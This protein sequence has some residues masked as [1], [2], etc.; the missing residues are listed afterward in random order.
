MRRYTLRLDGFVS[1]HGPAAEDSE[2]ITKVVTFEGAQMHLNFS[3]SA[4]GALRV[5][6][7]RPEGVALKN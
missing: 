6:V 1:V 7:Q 2:L 5:E 3:P 4:A